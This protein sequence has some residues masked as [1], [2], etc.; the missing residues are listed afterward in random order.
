MT[1]SS[2]LVH[3]DDAVNPVASSFV[4]GEPIAAGAEVKATVTVPASR[5]RRP[6]PVVAKAAGQGR[7]QIIISLTLPAATAETIIFIFWV[8]AASSIHSS[9]SGQRVTNHK[10]VPAVKSAADELPV[11]VPLQKQQQQ[12]LLQVA[13]KL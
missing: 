8:A 3:G 2:R 11:S 13:H 9:S 6:V 7:K 10:V 12:Q 4:K 1:K 5:A